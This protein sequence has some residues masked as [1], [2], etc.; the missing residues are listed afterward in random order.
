MALRPS[1]AG[2]QR[3]HTPPAATLAYTPAWC[4]LDCL[5]PLGREKVTPTG[6]LCW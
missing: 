4:L 2:V 6:T 3:S 5:F 1:I